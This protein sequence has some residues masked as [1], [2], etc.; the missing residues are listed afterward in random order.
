MDDRLMNR[1][2]DLYDW[3]NSGESYWAASGV[4]R[5]VIDADKRSGKIIYKT[6]GHQVSL[7]DTHIDTWVRW[8]ERNCAM[9]NH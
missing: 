8:C 1:P 3:P 6:I 2:V 9:R 7:R 4:C 5:L